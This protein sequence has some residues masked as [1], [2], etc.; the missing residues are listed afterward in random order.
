MNYYQKEKIRIIE[1][2][3]THGRKIAKEENNEQLVDIFQHILDECGSIN[4]N[5]VAS[6]LT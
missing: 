3:C 6:E 5:A 2:Q 1:K 4:I